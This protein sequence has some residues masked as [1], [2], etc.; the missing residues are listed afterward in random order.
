M[1]LIPNSSDSAK[2]VEIT[3]DRLLQFITGAAAGA[4]IVI[5]LICSMI[6]HN[7]KLKGALAVTEQSVAALEESNTALESTVSNLND[8]IEADK[9]VF[10]KIEDTISRREEEEAIEAEQAAVPNAIPV[11]NAKAIL[12]DDPYKETGGGETGGVVFSTTKGAVVA[13]AAAGL[14][15]HVDSDDDNIYYNR[16]IVIDHENGYSTYYRFNGD[17]SIEEGARVNKNDVLAVL[18]EDGFIAY[19]IKQD[20]EFIDPRGVMKE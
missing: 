14:V 10:S 4:I 18:T 11:K 15:T 13:A 3:Y 5:G 1:L 12:I 8:Q 16:G 9:K 20:G 7:Q 19:E 2:T 17:V 6:Y